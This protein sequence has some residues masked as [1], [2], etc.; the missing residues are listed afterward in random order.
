MESS[1]THWV[2]T[3]FNAINF[4]DKRLD[5]RFKSILTEFAKKSEANI[6]STFNSWANTKACY[7][8]LKN[9][10]VNESLIS[11]LHQEKT[12][13]RINALLPPSQPVLFIQD[14]TY[15]DYDKHTK[16]SHLDYMIR[17]PRST[18]IARGL[19]LHN[20]FALSIQGVPLGLIDQQ[21]I[22][23][24]KF[25]GPHPRQLRYWN[26]PIEEKESFRWI[27]TIKKCHDLAIHHRPIIHVTDR[28]GDIYELYRDAVELPEQF[29]IRARINRPINKKNV[30][31]RPAK[32]YLIRWN[33]KKPGVN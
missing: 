4:S 16:T 13:E 10:K 26:N 17:C 32:S 22:E 9:N 24:K 1:I 7:R 27:Q 25:H 5:K 14:T 20:T 15:I 33:R 21:F 6:A 19:L 23:R 12:V 2:E 11:A 3:E 28:E 30:E 31:N 29:I 8:F 18:K